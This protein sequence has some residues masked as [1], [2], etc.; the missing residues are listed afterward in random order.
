M[1][2]I[3]NDMITQYGNNNY[4]YC[5]WGRFSHLWPASSQ[6]PFPSVLLHSPALTLSSPENTLL[7]LLLVF[8]L[9]R[10]VTAAI[11]STPLFPIFCPLIPNFFQIQTNFVRPCH[12][13]FVSFSFPERQG[14]YSLTVVVIILRCS[15]KTI[16]Q[17][18]RSTDILTLLYSYRFRLTRNLNPVIVIK[19][20]IVVLH[21]FY[22]K[23]R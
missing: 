17:F 1:N 10:P 9:H 15:E 23:L 19:F 21:K 3:C 13:L 16:C 18:S 5:C 2:H 8:F 4:Y 20:I 12:S 14:S 22:L 6:L 7:L 11:F